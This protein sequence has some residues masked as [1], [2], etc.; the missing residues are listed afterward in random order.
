MRLFP[1]DAFSDLRTERVREFL[2]LFVL[3]LMIFAAGPASAQTGTCGTNVAYSISGDTITY[4]K[5]SA[6]SD[7]VWD[8]SCRSVIKENDSVQKVKASDTIRVLSGKE[9]FIH[10]SGLTEID[11]SNFD[12]SAMTSAQYMF[13]YCTGLT[14][15]DF[16]GWDASK[17][18]DMAG[19]FYA[20][21]S[22]TELDVSGWDTSNVTDMYNMFNGCG[23]LMVL[24]VGG[25]DI[26]SVTSIGWMFGYCS[27]LT[28]LAVS[29]WNTSAVTDMGGIFRDCS[30]LTKLDVSN[31]N[32]S[33]VIFMYEMFTNC[34]SLTEL[35]V[36]RWNTSKVEN[37]WMMF[38]GCTALTALDFS[39][40]DTSGV[41]MMD[42]MLF[43]LTSLRHLTLGPDF[44]FVGSEE[45]IISE[46][47]LTWIYAQ[48]DPSVRN[49]EV[50]LRSIRSIS[51]LVSS[52]DG[53][54]MAGSW[55]LPTEVSGS[56]TW[57][58]DADQNG[59]RPESVTVNLLADGV[60]MD[61]RTVGASDN[62]EW[63]FSPLP[64][65]RK[66]GEIGYTLSEDETAY[67]EA[68]V[69][70]YDITNVYVPPLTCFDVEI[71]WHDDNDSRR[72]RPARVSVILLADGVETGD[73]LILSRENNWQGSFSDLPKE[74]P[75]SADEIVYTVEARGISENYTTVR[76][77]SAAEGLIR[78]ESTLQI[79][80]PTFFRIGDG[81][82]HELPK[83]GLTGPAGAML[84]GEAS[85]SFEPLPMNL[86][87]PSLD[88]SL[89]MVLVSAADGEYPVAELA[90]KAG[91]LEG[92]DMPGEGWSVLVGHNTLNDIDYGPFVRVGMLEPGDRFFIRNGNGGL[93]IFEVYAN[94]KIGAEDRGALF[95]TAS[96]HLSTVT[97]MTC[98]DELSEGGYA[99][100]RIVSAKR[101]D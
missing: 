69:D 59:R 62:W 64:K 85:V 94:E 79:I 63:T 49:D 39:G 29:G 18:T 40:W 44:R 4:S 53:S 56:K 71:L 47:P 72:M 96:R 14:V 81:V 98:E 91:L 89:D 30:S 82:K 25:W 80:T 21:R 3:I 95:D 100:R 35:D 37:T 2:L 33:N 17:V 8:D 55:T 86:R 34:S 61:S 78:I 68:H 15:L 93:M 20:C 75:G 28:E 57:D 11:L 70:G 42:D 51:E 27:S 92:T 7:A 46:T 60:R 41:T 88:L 99:S 10:C 26:S 19:M 13:A 101:I 54:T 31:W 43:E 6:S 50:P 77:G 16:G 76:S 52:Y 1:F 24:D 45:N 22:L 90:D 38:R 67:Y 65:Y 23:N 58:D 36:S 97:L 9:M 48:K 83:T 5:Y 84:P 73:G 87:I 12:F 32:T 74:R 66:D